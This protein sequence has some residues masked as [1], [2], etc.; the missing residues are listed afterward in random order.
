VLQHG[1]RV[2]GFDDHLERG[3]QP[4]DGVFVAMLPDDVA[5]GFDLSGA[6]VECAL[7]DVGPSQEHDDHV[8]VH[9]FVRLHAE[10]GQAH[11]VLE[12]E[13]GRFARL[14]PGVS[15]QRLLGGAIQIRT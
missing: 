4:I 2:L 15:L 7:L 9:R 5:V 3:A 12:I 13:V 14:A 1:I 6:F 11:T 8:F 10:I